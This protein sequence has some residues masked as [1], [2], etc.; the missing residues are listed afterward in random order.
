MKEAGRQASGVSPGSE[1]ATP[2]ETGTEKEEKK[3]ES[4]KITES[5]RI[6]C[7][8]VV[9]IKNLVYHVQPRESEQKGETQ[10]QT[11]YACLVDL[12]NP[13]FQE[14]DSAPRSPLG[15]FWA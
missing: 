5:P 8:L 1:G 9:L 10:H 14:A 15:I 6:L 2:G 13:D 7:N 11:N 12:G 3:G 4:L